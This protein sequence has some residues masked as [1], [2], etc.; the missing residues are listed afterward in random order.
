MW[1]LALPGVRHLA[2]ARHELVAPGEL[3]ILQAA[4]RRELPL[5]LCRQLLARPARVGFRVRMGDVHDRVTS[6]PLIEL[7]AP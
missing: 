1:E 6:S 5:G 3:G 4:T 2:S 7:L